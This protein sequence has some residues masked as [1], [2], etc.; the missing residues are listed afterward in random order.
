MEASWTYEDWPAETMYFARELHSGIATPVACFGHG[1]V[2]RLVQCCPALERLWIPGLVQ[3]GVDVSAL[4]AL[5][6]LTALFV[7]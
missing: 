6:A 5:T 7:G 2:A 1:D 4:L 3:P